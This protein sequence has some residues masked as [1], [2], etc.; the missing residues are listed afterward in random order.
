MQN[1]QYHKHSMHQ[2]CYGDYKRDMQQPYLHSRLVIDSRIQIISTGHI[3][4]NTWLS[5]SEVNMDSEKVK[6]QNVQWLYVTR[7]HCQVII[8]DQRMISVV[9][10]VSIVTNSVTTE[11]HVANQI[12]ERIRIHHQLQLQ[13]LVIMKIVMKV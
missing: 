5:M 10:N 4:L 11:V 12:N 7:Q 1:R 13:Q 3:L 9:L 8:V 6:H 2:L